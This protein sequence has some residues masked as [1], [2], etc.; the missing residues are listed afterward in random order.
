[1]DIEKRLEEYDEIGAKLDEELAVLRKKCSEQKNWVH[2]QDEAELIYSRYDDILKEMFG[3]HLFYWEP[4]KKFP[5]MV[6]LEDKTPEELEALDKF[7]QIFETELRWE[8]SIIN[9]E[10]SE[11]V[12]SRFRSTE[13]VFEH[14]DY[15]VPERQRDSLNKLHKEGPVIKRWVP[16]RIPTE[17]E[18]VP[19]DRRSRYDDKS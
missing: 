18:F 12:W 1:M 9:E 8:K 10:W 16:G 14:Y 19:L 13:E 17:G 3:L 4:G 2:Y 5:R 15:E 11:Q 6:L 7:R